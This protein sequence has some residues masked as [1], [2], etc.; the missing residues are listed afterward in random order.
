M[1]HTRSEL[2]LF[3]TK[4]LSLGM[5]VYTTKEAMRARMLDTSSPAIVRYSFRVGQTDDLIDLTY[6][7]FGESYKSKM[8]MDQFQKLEERHLQILL[9]YTGGV[10]EE[11]AKLKARRKQLDRSTKRTIDYIFSSVDRLTK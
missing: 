6:V 10:D 7:V 2:D 4:A 3:S 8:T 1:P 9:S 5:V 11:Y